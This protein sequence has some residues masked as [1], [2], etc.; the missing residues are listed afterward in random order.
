[1]TALQFLLTPFSW[2]YEAGARLKAG[3]YKS[4]LRQIHQLPGVVISVGNLST[5]GTG[6]TPVVLWIAERLVA[7]GK[8]VGILTRGYRSEPIAGAASGKAVTST[9]DEVRMLQSRLGDS[10]MFGVGPDRYEEGRK[11]EQLGIDWFVLDDGFQHLQLARDVNIALVDATNPFGGG[12]L[13]PAGHLREPRSAV[14][15]AD[16]V[17][18]T[19]SHSAPAV[20]A[21]IRHETSAPIFR[22]EFALETVRT[23]RGVGPDLVPPLDAGIRWF[24]FS[25]IGNP[26]AFAKNLKQW[27]FNVVGRKNYPD[28][29]K[30][31][32]ADLRQIASA[33][34][35][36]GASK[37]VCTE[38]D[39]FNLPAGAEL[40]MPLYFCSI[41]VSSPE[42][43]HLWRAIQGLASKHRDSAK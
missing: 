20:E 8:R 4:G 28:H 21:M 32:A 16:I 19:R 31:S 23:V 43:E 3:A 18:I 12:R 41:K 27:N 10:V 13:L 26:S 34:A 39:K 42:E 14:S 7:E 17:V 1:M 2:L 40:G 37:I 5:G 30:Y 36:A 22:V 33:A 24:V 9:S 11:L 29:H 6:K 38:K 25:G 15:R 35:A